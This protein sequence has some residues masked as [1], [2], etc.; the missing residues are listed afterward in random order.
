MQAVQ[1][2]RAFLKPRARTWAF[3][4]PLHLVAFWVLYF[5]TAHLLETEV[6]AI[7]Q[8]TASHLL[9]QSSKQLSQ[10]AVA[11]TRNRALKHF[12][13][14]VLTRN[15]E[16]HLQLLLPDGR[17]MGADARRPP[18]ETEDLRSFVAGP[19]M[20]RFWLREDDTL[21]VA[22]LQGLQ[23]V[24]ASDACIRCHAAGG[25][26]AVASMNLDLTEILA[27]LQGRSR[28]NIALLIIAW[29]AALGASTAIVRSSVLRSARQSGRGIGSRRGR[30]RGQ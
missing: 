2:L 26:L 15:Q 7:A 10:I 8:R 29:A 13:E 11:H 20:Q 18:V 25:T 24:V 14:A 12:F 9:D 4:I 1:R 27:S 5:A 28:R 17:V 3:M 23:K 21:D 16:I 19:Q 22:Q 6:V 30:R